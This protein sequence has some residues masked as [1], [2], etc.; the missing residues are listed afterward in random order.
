MLLNSFKLILINVY[1]DKNS[2]N[3]F[4]RYEREDEGQI[5]NRCMKMCKKCIILIKFLY[6]RCTCIFIR[7]YSCAISR[8]GRTKNIRVKYKNIYCDV[9]HQ[10]AW[11]MSEKRIKFCRFKSKRQIWIIT[12]RKWFKLVNVRPF[13]NWEIP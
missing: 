6:F 10:N 11:H 2:F 9:L 12:R 7:V 13:Q 4:S 8:I 1:C 3:Q 5:S